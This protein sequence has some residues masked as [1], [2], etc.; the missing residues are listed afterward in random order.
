MFECAGARQTIW[1]ACEIAAPGGHLMQVGSGE[2]DQLIF[3]SG[4]CRRK[5]LTVRV[6]RRS[7]NTL[8][9]CIDLC[10]R[11][12]MDPGALVTHTFPARDVR[13]AFEAVDRADEGLLKVVVDM[14]QW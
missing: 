3:S 8:R 2:D 7:L 4:T 5:G 6:V 14:T 9:P 10:E 11:G 1:N 13:S 12:A